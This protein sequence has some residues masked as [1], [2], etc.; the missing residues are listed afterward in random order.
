LPYGRH[1]TNDHRSL[2]QS[3]IQ[4]MLQI[5]AGIRLHENDIHIALLSIAIF[6]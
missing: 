4:D 2:H 3:V 5:I 6:S 1:F